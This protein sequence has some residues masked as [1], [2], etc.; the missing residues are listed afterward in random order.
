MV[1]KMKMAPIG[2]SE[3]KKLGGK[4]KALPKMRLPKL[5]LI[6]HNK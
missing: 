6:G 3:T 2:P 1:K 4:I 5:K